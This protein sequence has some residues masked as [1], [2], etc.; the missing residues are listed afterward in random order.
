MQR[1]CAQFTAYHTTREAQRLWIFAYCPHSVPS[2]SGKILLQ[3][4]TYLLSKHLI[5]K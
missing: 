3:C 5:S 4:S 2:I 1:N